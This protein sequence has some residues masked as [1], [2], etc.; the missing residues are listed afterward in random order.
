[1]DVK[2][3]SQYRLSCRQFPGEANRSKNAP[4]TKHVFNR[5]FADEP[6][7]DG[8]SFNYLRHDHIS[9]EDLC[10]RALKFLKSPN[11]ER[12]M[13]K[14]DL[15]QTAS[16]AR[17]L[18]LGNPA[19]YENLLADI[20]EDT[21]RLAEP[22]TKSEHANMI[23]DFRK[24]TSIDSMDKEHKMAFYRELDDVYARLQEKTFPAYV[25]LVCDELKR[26]GT[27]K[28]TI[29]TALGSGSG[30]PDTSKGVDKGKHDAGKKRTGTEGNQPG[31]PEKKPRRDPPD[32]ANIP[33]HKRCPYCGRMSHVD[34]KTGNPMQCSL[35]N[36]KNANKDKSTP[37]ALSKTGKH[38]KET[39]GLDTLP[40]NKYK[41]K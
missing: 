36:D 11:P 2:H 14:A 31:K 28:A 4:R 8:E 40:M 16:T 30:N 37:W 33:N 20:M 15:K 32:W 24:N 39:L 21:I 5:I 34:N 13:Y 3:L 29:D 23:T 18:T 26:L 41:S 25:S 10:L 17:T 1:M 35:I 12:N 27:M 9:S 6:D 22:L 38:H 7:V 19:V